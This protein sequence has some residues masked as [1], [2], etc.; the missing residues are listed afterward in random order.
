MKAK[1]GGGDED[2]REH[3]LRCEHLSSVEVPCCQLWPLWPLWSLLPRM[4]SGVCQAFV[5]AL[6]C[7]RAT[8]D[9]RGVETAEADKKPAEFAAVAAAAEASSRGVS[10]NRLIAKLGVGPTPLLPP[11]PP[12][13]LFGGRP[14]VRSCD[15]AGF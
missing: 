5:A 10:I 1:G 2:T 15:S 8:G 4:S 11:P 7:G 13:P 3:V 14:W 6:V 12:P 9:P